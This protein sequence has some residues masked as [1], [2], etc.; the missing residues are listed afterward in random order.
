MWRMIRFCVAL[1]LLVFPGGLV[2]AQDSEIITVTGRYSSY[3]VGEYQEVL[4]PCGSLDVCGRGVQWSGLY[5]A[6]ASVCEPKDEW[7]V[8]EA[9]GRLCGTPRTSYRL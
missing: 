3:E 1:L 6:Y 7:T 2:G 9:Q 4:V 8:D 5:R